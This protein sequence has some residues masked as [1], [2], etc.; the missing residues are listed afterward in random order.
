MLLG[1]PTCT[2]VNLQ[3][4]GAITGV[5]Y[6]PEADLKLGGGGSTTYDFVGCIMAKTATLTGHMNFHFDEALRNNSY[7]RGYIVTNWKE[8]T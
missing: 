8:K 1:L 3:G 5:V 6:A 2:A 4:N 7:S